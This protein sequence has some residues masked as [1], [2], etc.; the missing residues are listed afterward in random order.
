MCGIAALSCSCPSDSPA[1]H[2][3]GTDADAE[4][5][6]RAALDRLAHRGPDGT[7]IHHTDDPDGGLLL[8]HRRLAI[9]D[10]ALGRQ[11]LVAP[12]GAALVANGMIYNDRALRQQLAHEPYV[13]GSDSESILHLLRREG[14][15]AVSRLDGMFGFVYADGDRVI[16]ARDPLGIKPLYRFRIG[17]REGFASEVKAFDGVAD[18]VEEFPP[19][20]VYDTEGG[21]RPYYRV[22]E[23]QDPSTPP[24]KAVAELREVLEA[25]VVKRLRSDVPLGCLLSGGLDSSLIA[26][27]ASQHVEQLHTFAVGLEGSPDLAAA[28]H[29]SAHLGTAHHELV[30]TPADV[31]AAVPEALWHL[32]S[33]DVDLVRSAVGTWLVM[34]FASRHVTV[35]LTGE[36]ADELF[37]GYGYYGDYADPAQLQAEL[38]RSITGM[39]DVNLQ[40]VDRMS[41]AHGVEARVPFLDVSVVDVAMRTPPALKQRDP[42][43]G[44]PAPKWVLRAVADGLLPEEVVWRPKAQF[45][46]GS[47]LADLLPRMA[48]PATGDVRADRAR[49][50]RRY[51]ALLSEQFARPD[52]V[53]QV[54]G[55]W[56]SD[57]L[58]AAG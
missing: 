57:R 20:H 27:L 19:G 39:H 21:L 29:V 31:R 6:L 28:R 30:M 16:A 35:V 26:A 53:L 18:E 51:R 48:G 33:A 43:T 49:E 15:E 40:R 5:A 38:H 2:D 54:A 50:G 7:G 4:P 12:D 46:E 37:A 1:D 22:P 47:G 42:R 8:G 44:R 56:A 14:P 3:G 25:A 17:G 24:D 13:T 36:G 58:A 9:I 55:T 45:D 52:L 11:P 10:P 41:M 32:E 34:E 23:P